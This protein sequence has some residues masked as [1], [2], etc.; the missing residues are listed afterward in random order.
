[1]PKKRCWWYIGAG[2]VDVSRHV[3]HNVLT[4]VRIRGKDDEKEEYGEKE[5]GRK[6]DEIFLKAAAAAALAMELSTLTTTSRSAPGPSRCK[7]DG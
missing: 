3:W 6:H 4:T 2:G 7:Y 1:V 5:G